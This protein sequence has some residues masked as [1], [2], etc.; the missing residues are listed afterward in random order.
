MC[1]A[2][3]VFVNPVM[4]LFMK[5]KFKLFILEVRDSAEKYHLCFW[6]IWGRNIFVF[7]VVVVDAALA[8]SRQFT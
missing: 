1:T 7:V 4:G 3:F 8:Y 5:G 6:P 2:F